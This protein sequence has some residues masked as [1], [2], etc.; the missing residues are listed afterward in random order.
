MAKKQGSSTKKNTLK[1]NPKEKTGREKQKERTFKRCIEICLMIEEG[2]PLRKALKQKKLSRAS[3]YD[4][5]DNDA[6]NLER[7]ARAR[8]ERAALIFE[9]MLDIADDQENDTYTDNEGIE[10]VNHNVIN[11]SKIRLDTR[12]WML[13]RMDKKYNERHI[14]EGGDNPIETVVTFRIPENGRE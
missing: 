8:E 14:I 2:S 9:D 7:Y 6:K 1:K 10:Q 11:R 12:K 5:I 13:A 3:F 4:W